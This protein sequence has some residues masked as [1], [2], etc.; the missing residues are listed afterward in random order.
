[1]ELILGQF[2]QTG[3]L[4]LWEKICPIL[5][6]LALG[7]VFV[8]L[9]MAMFYNT[10][11]AWSIY[12]LYLS[13]S[14]ILPWQSCTNEWNT[15][16]CL[17]ISMID[18]QRTFELPFFVNNRENQTIYRK[19]GN[20]LVFFELDNIN[21]A[22]IDIIIET[23]FNRNLAS[24][25]SS[26]F[27]ITYTQDETIHFHNPIDFNLNDSIAYDYNFDRTIYSSN[28]DKY[29]SEKYTNYSI[30]LNCTKF[31]TSPTQEFFNR[32]LVEINKSK[33][34]ESLGGIKW[35]IA[36]CLFI[37]FLTVYFALWKGIKSAG[38]V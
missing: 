11:I 17:P 34:L 25:I 20:K 23:N 7:A 2:H 9:L 36:L 31:M 13:F 8:N 22:P 29:I 15:E 16:C 1:M 33:G 14:T 28:L 37:V 4:T 19:I 12:Y 27:V 21:T 26:Y 30:I 6:G 35:Q 3:V 32:F 24:W 18:N 5:K 38:K 10:I